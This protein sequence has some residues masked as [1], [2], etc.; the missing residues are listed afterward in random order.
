[1]SPAITAVEI[2]ALDGR[3]PLGFLAALGLLHLLDEAGDTSVEPI[4]LS[5]STET[6]ATVLSS[7]LPTVDA[8]V[9]TLAS[10]VTAAD[11]EAAIIGIHPDFPLRR[12]PGDGA[13]V[14]EG[15]GDGDPMR[16]PRQRFQELRQQVD[17]LG[18]PAA[19]AWLRA[20]VTDLAVD[21]AGRAALTPYMAPSGRQTTRTFFAKSLELVRMDP[22]CI[23]EALTGWRRVDG[24]S[25]EY[26]DHRVIRDAAHHPSGKSTEAGVPGATWLATQA[27][28]LLR[29]TGDGTNV[30]ATLWHR[31][32]RRSIMTWPLWHTPLDRFAIRDLLE[33]PLLRPA[34]PTP[35]RERSGP[36]VARRP[37]EPLGVFDIAGAERQ[38][39]EGRKSAGVL[40]PLPIGA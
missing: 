25:G 23:A 29:L 18:D 24:F 19:S 12:R 36:T 30:Q 35:H 2:P 8:I 4:R 39:I 15:A 27:L 16:I 5:F 26:L 40:A 11:P 6:R 7:P 10:K 20:L 33:H 37:L 9:E 32:D 21:R 13:A 1:M 28:A 17:Q 22:R 3:D 31:Y 34:R 14:D 38:L